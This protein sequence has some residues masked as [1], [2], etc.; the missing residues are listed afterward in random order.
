MREIGQ[1]LEN[2]SEVSNT[3]TV[4]LHN[5]FRTLSTLPILSFFFKNPEREGEKKSRKNT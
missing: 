2:L 1:I 3:A 5:L 4:Q